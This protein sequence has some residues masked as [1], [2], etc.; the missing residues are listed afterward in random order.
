MSNWFYWLCKLHVVFKWHCRVS[1]LDSFLS[2][3]FASC[4][5]MFSFSLIMKISIYT[6]WSLIVDSTSSM[7]LQLVFM[8]WTSLLFQTLIFSTVWKHIS[9]YPEAVLLTYA[10][11]PQFKGEVTLWPSFV[12]LNFVPSKSQFGSLWSDAVEQAYTYYT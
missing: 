12:Y 6:Y 2:D 11:E 4:L 8:E 7:I 5:M 10:S 1:L 9:A 3:S